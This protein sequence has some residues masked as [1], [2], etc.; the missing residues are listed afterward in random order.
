MVTSNGSTGSVVTARHAKEVI[1][2]PISNS[3]AENFATWIGRELQS[4]LTERFGS[5]AGQFLRVMVSETSGQHG[6]YEWLDDADVLTD[7][8]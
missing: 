2:L 4:R 7:E 3:S 6:V 8:G 1:L 5:Y